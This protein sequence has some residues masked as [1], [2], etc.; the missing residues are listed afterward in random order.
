MK[1]SRQRELVREAVEQFQCHPTA[2]M[3]YQSV[4]KREPTISLATVY[5]NLHQLAEHG[6]IRC[7]PILG[8][9]DRFDCTLTPH[10]HMICIKCGSVVDI[11]PEE[12]V[13]AYFQEMQKKHRISSYHLVLHGICDACAALEHETES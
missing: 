7:I 2:D 12:S 13:L 1:Y 10:E 6:M 9:S 3:V 11:F 5:R 4:R 8:D